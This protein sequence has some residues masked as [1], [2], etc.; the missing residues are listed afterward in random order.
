MDDFLQRYLWL[1][2]EAT[3]FA[4]VIQAVRRYEELIF[5]IKQICK[6][7]KTG[8]NLIAEFARQQRGCSYFCLQLSQFSCKHCFSNWKMENNGATHNFMTVYNFYD[9]ICHILPDYRL[10]VLLSTRIKIAWGTALPF[11]C[12][13]ILALRYEMKIWIPS[14]RWRKYYKSYRKWSICLRKT[15]KQ[16]LFFVL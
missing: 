13:D 10:P 11:I 7:Y 8:M 14:A 1:F 3:Y 2:W 6:K 5:K 9:H 15:I 16:A 4:L 12:T